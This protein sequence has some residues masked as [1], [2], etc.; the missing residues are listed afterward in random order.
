M[1]DCR[2]FTH[3]HG[4]TRIVMFYGACVLWAEVK[5][6]RY[7]PSMR[8]VIPETADITSSALAVDHRRWAGRRMRTRSIQ[9]PADQACREPAGSVGQS[10]S[11]AAR[12]D[13][14]RQQSVD[15]LATTAGRGVVPATR[16]SS[17][18][19]PQA[20]FPPG[21]PLRPARPWPMVSSS[22]HHLNRP[23]LLA[24]RW[25][26]AVTLP[27]PGASTCR[28]RIRACWSLVRR[29]QNNFAV[30][31]TGHHLC[32]PAAARSF[33]HLLGHRRSPAF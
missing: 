22:D 30:W 8:L 29:P 11:R 24:T 32:R 18:I 28:C 23:V 19:A 1:R 7:N 17:D 21:R 27:P 12:Y 15:R 20:C 2:V 25:P 33:A 13:P 26:C 14:G 16:T 6:I 31:V 4:Q 9:T 10:T 3:T 5:V